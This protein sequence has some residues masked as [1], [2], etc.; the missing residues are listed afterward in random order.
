M[1]DQPWCSGPTLRCKSFVFDW[2]EPH[3]H[4]F[5]LFFSRNLNGGS[6]CRSYF[7]AYSVLIV[8][9]L[10]YL[11]W[12][13]AVDLSQCIFCA[14]L[15]VR[16]HA[17]SIS[18]LFFSQVVLNDMAS[19]Y[20]R[21]LHDAVMHLQTSL[22]VIFWSLNLELLYMHCLRLCPPKLSFCNIAPD[23]KVLIL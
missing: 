12:C 15:K 10:G 2:S 8:S 9:F 14:S 3:I 17:L 1:H 7:F 20:W 6:V 13:W 22:S 16:R 5:V 11:T 19:Q 18:F 4:S 21:L 23:W